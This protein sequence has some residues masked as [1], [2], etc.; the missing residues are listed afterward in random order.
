[1][2]SRLG[3]Y[4]KQLFYASISTAFVIA[5][6]FIL[7]YGRIVDSS[8]SFFDLYLFNILFYVTLD[9]RLEFFIFYSIS[10]LQIT[11]NYQKFLLILV[12]GMLGFF[13]GTVNGIYF[14]LKYQN[15]KGDQKSK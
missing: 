5:L 9:W 8:N 14:T 4:S 15:K 3:G 1:M 2:S 13:I 7:N 6:I 12:F 10:N 11:T